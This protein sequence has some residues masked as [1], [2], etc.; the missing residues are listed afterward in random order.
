[1]PYNQIALIL[2]A[3][4]AVNW[5]IFDRTVQGL[6][7]ATLC[8]LGAPASE[9][10]L[11]KLLHVWHYAKPGATTPPCWQEFLGLILGNL[12]GD[13]KGWSADL[14]GALAR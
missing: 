4:A 13:E 1:M 7:L 12:S 11:M 14:L 8:G 2:A 5:R 10:L 9:L 3:C 6:L